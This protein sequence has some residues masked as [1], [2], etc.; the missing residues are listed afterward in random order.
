MKINIDLNEIAQELDFELE[1]VEM[2]FEAFLENAY[3]MLDSLENAIAK[4]DMEGVFRSAHSIKGSAANLIF[5]KLSELAKEIELDAR[6][7]LD[8]D[9]L[10]SYKIL[11]DEIIKLGTL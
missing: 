2:L 6:Q 8:K 3:E 1:D 11:R 9:Y 10:A 7:G 4:N 5:D